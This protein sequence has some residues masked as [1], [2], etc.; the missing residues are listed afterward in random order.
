M[1]TKWRRK[2]GKEG[3]RKIIKK[4]GGMVVLRKIRRVELGVQQL[5]ME[6]QLLKRR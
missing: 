6:K 2:P 1:S 3:E 4:Y 5:P